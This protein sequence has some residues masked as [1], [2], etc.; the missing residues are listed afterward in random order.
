[1]CVGGVGGASI[2]SINS[3]SLECERQVTDPTP[4]SVAEA[5]LI[6]YRRIV[7]P[8]PRAALDVPIV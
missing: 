5:A 1:M 4:P 7:R 8:S 2:H 3:V 6:Y